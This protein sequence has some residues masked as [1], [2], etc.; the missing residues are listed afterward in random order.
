MPCC[1]SVL[2]KNDFECDEEDEVKDTDGRF[3][4]AFQEARVKIPSRGLP[5]SFRIGGEA[6]TFREADTSFAQQNHSTRDREF[7]FEI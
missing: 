5:F 1:E 7:V 4:Y 2:R 3:I 6:Q